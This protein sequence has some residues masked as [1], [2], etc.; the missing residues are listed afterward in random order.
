MR[1]ML[2]SV[3]HCSQMSNP[4]AGTGSG[5]DRCC[6]A[7]AAILFC[8]FID[9]SKDAEQTMY[10]ITEAWNNG[11]DVS[12]LEN[13]P[14]IEQ[15]ISAASGGA[16]S[17][18][19]VTPDY[20]SIVACV[21]RGHVAI[22]GVND[23][24]QLRSFDGGD[25]YQWP[26][27]TQ[28]PA[29]HVLLCIG[30]D[31]NYAGHGATLI[32]MDP[33]RGIGGQP[34]DYRLDSVSA[35]GWASLVEVEAPSLWPAPPPPPPGREYTVQPGDSLWAIA[36]REYGDPF[37]YREIAADNA[38]KYPSLATDLDYIVTGWVLSLPG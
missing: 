8:T 4:K 25:P 21:Q 17:F 14:K 1:Q 6:E 28:P 35:A 18:S 32:V 29:G 9:T 38:A 34:W 19:D 10:H 5:G 2:P 11:S 3:A 7:V 15:D 23:Y 24:R 22:I 12:A 13:T 20:S 16:I 37:K 27:A 36:Q 26:T 31:D 33:L 30:T